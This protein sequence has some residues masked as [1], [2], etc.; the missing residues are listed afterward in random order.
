MFKKMKAAWGKW[1]A[2]RRQYVIERAQY[3]AGGGGDA[4]HGGFEGKQPPVGGP[5]VPL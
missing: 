1:R 3:K 4:R 5:N 2:S